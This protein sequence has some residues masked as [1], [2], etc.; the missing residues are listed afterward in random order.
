MDLCLCSILLILAL[1][2]E[3]EGELE[4][5]LE[6]ELER[7]LEGELEREL[8]RQRE[9]QRE[10]ANER[11]PEKKDIKRAFIWRGRTGGTMPCRVLLFFLSISETTLNLRQDVTISKIC[12]SLFLFFLLNRF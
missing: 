1:K 9:R 7:Q 2:K 10:S 6:G 5:Q 11:A 3:L 4:R 12:L 8:E